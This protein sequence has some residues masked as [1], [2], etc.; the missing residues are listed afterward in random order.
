MSVQVENL[1]KNMVKLTIEVPAEELEKAIDAAY[2]KQKN[3]ISIPGFRKGK[4]P[5]AMVEKMYGVEV[6][7]EDAANT[8]MQQNYP[9][10]VEESGVDIVSRPSIDVVQIE[11]G[12]PF[13]YTA[14]V[15]VRPE[16]TLGKYMG[17]T[18]TKIDTSVSD[19]EVAEALEQ[20]RNNNAR[21]IS[22]TDRPVAVGD[23]A[24]ID[25]EGFVDGVAFEGGKGENHPLEIGSHTFIDNFEDQLVGKNAGDEVEV[26]VTFPEQ[27]QAADLAGKP[28]TFKVKIN[29]IKAKELPELDDEFAQDV[30]E[31]D[32][33]AEYK[34]SLKKNL[35]EKKENEAK[36]TKEDEAV[37]K[38]IDKSK[39]DIPEA[40]IDTQCETMIEEFAQRITQSGL[41]MDQYLQFSGLT[42]DGLKEQVRPE[43]LSR[44]QASLVLEQIAKDENI[45]VSDD[46]VN[47]EIEKMAASY[48]M[49]ADKLK[50][51]MGDAEKESM[52]K[53]LAINKAVELVMSNVKER[54]K[55]KSKKEKEAEEGAEA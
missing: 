2:K 34:E 47:A 6:F 36:R 52:K 28:A 43:A 53:D 54:A 35:E 44:I 30:S 15:A 17:V 16:V 19:D 8:L 4:V 49:E 12:K 39:M 21:T 1:E 31:F 50:E 20:Q 33:L 32:T 7:Y 29:E 26:N 5:R 38:I 14:E 9:S 22:V 37:Q 42:V 23:T 40:M 11:K 25:F 18:V 45:E 46:D 41:S 24:V 3:Q 13:I 27:Y 55:A 48:G 10:A 51:Y